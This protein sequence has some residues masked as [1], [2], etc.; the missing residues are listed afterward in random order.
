MNQ[1]FD[2]VVIGAGPA[3]NSAAFHLAKSGYRVAVIDKRQ[4]IGNK[5]CTGIIGN[6]CVELFQPEPSHI[7]K[8]VKSATL[9]T[10]SG[11]SHNITKSNVQGY[12]VNRSEYVSSIA[13]KAKDHG[14]TYILGKTVTSISNDFSSA[15]VEFKTGEIK[16]SLNCNVIIIA[17]GFNSSIPTMIGLPNINNRGYM[18]GAQAEV[19]LTKPTD[20]QVYL[21]NKVSPGSF[22]WLA[23]LDDS[24]CL[25]GIASRNKLNGHMKTFLDN[26]Q[27][28]GK[29]NTSDVKIKK[30]GIP[31][32]PLSKTY[33]NRV[34]VIGDAAG[35]TKPT[36]GGGIYY[37]ILSGEISANV[38][39]RCF[40][41]NNFS[42]SSM[43]NYEAEWKNRL[44]KE[45]KVG[46]YARSIF[47]K[48]SDSQIEKLVTNLTSEKNPASKILLNNFSFDWHSNAINQALNQ[49][50]IVNL[51]KSFGTNLKPLL[52]QFKE[53]KHTSSK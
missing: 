31:I 17:T 12:I 35:F 22:G 30:W 42:E 16:E 40:A 51:F 14:A 11:T 8:K 41:S 49:F 4:E 20:T 24:N 53:Q 18:I 9:V 52:K 6:N 45:M 46:Y 33:S 5:L 2:I 29:I 50:D 38:I 3:G 21:G 39:K 37:G 26:L 32:K 10:P 25:V 44:G 48:L 7:Y 43:K 27:Q 23:P 47:E 34:L 13:K 28:S 15:S 19:S 36:T 1:T